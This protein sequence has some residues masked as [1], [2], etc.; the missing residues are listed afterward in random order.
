MKFTYYFDDGCFKVKQPFFFWAILSV[1]ILSACTQERYIDENEKNLFEV[2]DIGISV[3]QFESKYVNHLIKTGRND[4]KLERYR[5][6]DEYIDNLL[7]AEASSEMGLLNHPIYLS[8]INFQQRKSMMDVYFVDE[9]DKV[10]E[11][12]TDD[13]VRRAY[14]KKQMQVY[15]RQLFSIN[16]S[17]LWEAYQRLENGESFVDVANDHFETEEYDSLA[18]YLGPIRY[19]AVDDAFAE[20]AYSLNQGEHSKPIRSLYGYHIVYIEYLEFP[21]ILAEDAYQYA[22]GGIT[23]QVRLRKQR[24]VSNNYVRDLMSTLLVEVDPKHVKTLRESISALSE[25]QIQNI[26]QTEERKSDFWDDEKRNRLDGLLDNNATLATF[27]LKGNRVEFTF[28]DYLKWLP[29]LSFSEAKNKTGAS[30]GRAL[31][32][33]V[34]YLLA[35]QNN[36]AE[37]E[38]V[39]E[40][41]KERGYEVLSELHQYELTMQAISDTNSIEVPKS[42]ADRLIRNK[43]IQIKA[44]YWKIPVA[45]LKDAEEVKNDILSGGLPISYDSYTKVDY[46]IINPLHDDYTLVKNGLLNTP[47]IGHTSSEGWMVIKL[48]E[49]DITTINEGMPSSGLQT[50]Y[51][52]FKTINDRVEEL[53]D[54]ATIKVDTLL[55]NNIYDL[56]KRKKSS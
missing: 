21:A 16:E 1:T 37:D 28:D 47:I 43:Q 51:K 13:E 11:P 44:S 12:P 50:D 36:Y 48:S 54:R 25:D 52:V 42:F 26:T 30:V 35:D 41:V 15:V 24:L 29:Y 20:A 9:M 8:A 33:E 39:I 34:F 32:N 38:R 40:K 53:R 22:K 45:G 46:R 2:N 4:S 10:I 23:S 5:Y 31:R 56:K 7:L 3:Y 27:V 17:D 14:A 6:I 55:F 49:R 19:F 18:G